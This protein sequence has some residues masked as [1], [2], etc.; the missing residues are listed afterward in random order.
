MRI[1]TPSALVLAVAMV[2]VLAA[3]Q[4]FLPPPPGAPVDP[5]L[6]FEVVSLRAADN[7]SSPALMRMTPGGFEYSNLP[8]GVL[9]RQALQKPD[10]QIVGL[11]G[12]ADQDRY[13]IRAKPPEGAPLSA[14]TTMLLNLL[15]DRFQLA[16]HLET[17][18]LPISHLVVARTDG[19]LGPD[20]K[21][22]SAECQATIAERNA[23]AKA[24]AGR[25]GPPPPLPS[26]PGPNDP[27]PC[28]FG[29]LNAG[30]AA[31]SGRTIAQLVPT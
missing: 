31:G 1:H 11:P 5:N 17:R 6:R 28:G 18:E 9:V 21:P 30:I 14:L 4:Q 2:P 23:A 22:T 8:I 7:A 19:R 20:L 12:W 25:G 10:Y 27:L 29:R 26:F 3:A 15:K 16:M 13:T 24:A